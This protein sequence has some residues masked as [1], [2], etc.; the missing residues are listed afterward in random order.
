MGAFEPEA[1]TPRCCLHKKTPLLHR[2]SYSPSVVGRHLSYRFYFPN[3]FASAQAIQLSITKEYTR[4]KNKAST[5]VQRCPSGNIHLITFERKVPWS[6]RGINTTVKTLAGYGGKLI[7][8]QLL[9]TCLE[10]ALR[11][12]IFFQPNIKRYWRIQ[13]RTAKHRRIQQLKTML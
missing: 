13:R 12:I 4:T 7:L 2:P 1:G 6:N 10:S 3:F 11:Q 9:N 5:I 8:Y